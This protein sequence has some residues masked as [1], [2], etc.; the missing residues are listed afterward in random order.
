MLQYRLVH[1]LSCLLW[2]EVKSIQMKLKSAGWWNFM[3][4]IRDYRTYFVCREPCNGNVERD[5]CV[6]KDWGQTLLAG[7]VHFSEH[8]ATLFTSA[9][10]LAC[11]PIPASFS[12]MSALFGLLHSSSLLRY[13]SS[14]YFFFLSLSTLFFF[15]L[16]LFSSSFLSIY[17]LPLSSPCSLFSE[18]WI[19]N[20]SDPASW[21][22]M[23]LDLYVRSTNC[24][25]TNT[26]YKRNDNFY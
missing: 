6:K 3:H 24:I 23:F 25:A 21:L 14:S 5:E 19:V 10:S 8:G 9:P 26:S 16:L 20:V 17:F 22:N 2:K 1:V 11:F 18:C 13:F 7:I 12:S 4:P 15:S